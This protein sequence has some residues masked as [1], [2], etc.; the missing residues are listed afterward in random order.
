M[1]RGPWPPTEPPPEVVAP[2]SWNH[3]LAKQPSASHA[4]SGSAGS[5]K[6][7]AALCPPTEAAPADSAGQTADSGLMDGPTTATVGGESAGS[8]VLPGQH[9]LGGT[10]SG[11]ASDYKSN[12]TVSWI[13]LKTW[14][15]CWDDPVTSQVELELG[16]RGHQQEAVIEALRLKLANQYALP[17]ADVL[18]DDEVYAT[19]FWSDFHFHFKQKKMS[20]SEVRNTWDPKPGGQ[21]M[22]WT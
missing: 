3:V 18:D 15:N 21:K 17:L 6:F 4:D 8:G 16:A 1:P 20:I 19:G 11:S 10:S 7:E 2:A 12:Y 5:A 9:P 13:P 22:T 14:E